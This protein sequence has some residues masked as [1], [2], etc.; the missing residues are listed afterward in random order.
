MAEMEVSSDAEG[1]INAQACFIIRSRLFNEDKLPTKIDVL[2]RISQAYDDLLADENKS[3]AL[4]F[5][6]VNTV[7]EVCTIWKK[8]S[9]PI[10][11]ENGIT[12]KMKRLL[13]DY[14]KYKKYKTR[15]DSK[16]FIVECAQIFDIAKCKC[17]SGSCSCSL[18]DKIPQRFKAF[19][20][21]QRGAR[22][23]RI[24]ELD[25]TAGESL[26]DLF[27][28]PV[29]EMATS[30]QEEPSGSDYIPA[31]SSL[32]DFSNEQPKYNPHRPMP[33]L[34]TECDR[35]GVPSRLAAALVSAAFKDYEVTNTGNPLGNPIVIDKN[36]IER[37]REANRKDMLE[38]PKSTGSI[39]AFSFDGRTDQTRVQTHTSDGKIHPR[40]VTEKH[41]TILKQSGSQFL[42]YVVDKR[43]E[44]N[45]K[46]PAQQTA[47]LLFDF[48]GVRGLDLTDLLLVVLT[49]KL[50]ILVDTKVF[51]ET[52]KNCLTDR[53]TGSFACCTSTSYACIMYRRK[54]TNHERLDLERQLGR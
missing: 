26:S 10:I 48:F 23:L 37:E 13:T 24:S 28:G 12:L 16:R 22:R 20:S 41:V 34:A 5:F 18:V 49:E 15:D 52:W 43:D 27:L 31:I 36:K 54:L 50:K 46:K 35:Y 9:I 53:Y 44:E 25:Q 29:T 19:I 6:V 30:T 45:H 7:K 4:E 40:M 11:S 51:C 17:K 1:P 32:E 39:I 8:T 42:G 3:E 38:K 33:N 14:R 2:S 21:D 47:K